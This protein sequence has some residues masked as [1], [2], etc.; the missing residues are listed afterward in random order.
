[1]KAEDTPNYEH[2]YCAMCRAP[3]TARIKIDENVRRIET[4]A[5]E[6]GNLRINLPC[7][8]SSFVT[9]INAELK[10]LVSGND[11]HSVRIGIGLGFGIPLDGSVEFE[12][13]SEDDIEDIV[14][15]LRKRVDDVDSNNFIEHSDLNSKFFGNIE[16]NSKN[17][18]EDTDISRRNVES[19]NLRQYSEDNV[20][21]RK[22]KCV[23]EPI[24]NKKR[25]K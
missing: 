15:S 18:V 20:E 4:L 13:G 23:V 25:R 5:N 11:V 9:E 7:I 2:W 3:R 24:E 17:L 21:T 6:A 10:K 12:D 14:F 16:T 19:V 1:M 22:R 8:S